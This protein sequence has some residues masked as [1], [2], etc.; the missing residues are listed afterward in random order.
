MKV[1]VIKYN[2][3]NIRSVAFAL[4]R[5]GVTFTI[6]D[7][8]EEIKSADKVIFPG[9]GEASTTMYYLKER[10]LDTVIK[11]LKQPVLGICLG[12]QLMCAHSEENNTP[13]LGI[14]DETVR[15]FEP[16]HHQK[17][18]HM[19]W[20]SLN[21]SK[22]WLNQDLEGEFVY[23]VHSYYVPL[24]K[25]TVATTEYILPFSS[26]LQKGN[27]YAVQFHPEKSSNAGELV[28]KSFFDKSR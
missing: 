23:F 4:E 16:S 1:A 9:V 5:L 26:A 17:V 20:N 21:L 27:F 22:G 11:N 25:Q 13:C 24:S 2:A 15:L 18:P 3:G 19:G 28:L 8:P 6:T 7:Q 14:F 10:K 12:M